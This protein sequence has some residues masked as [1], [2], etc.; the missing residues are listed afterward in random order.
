MYSYQD[1]L[2]AVKLYLKL[3]RRLKETLLQLGYANRTSLKEWTAEFEQ[4]QDLHQSRRAPKTQYTPE[5]KHVPSL[6]M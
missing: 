6:I 1:R 4:N 2:H 3:G 5:K